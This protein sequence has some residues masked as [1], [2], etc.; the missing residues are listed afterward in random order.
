MTGPEHNEV[1]VRPYGPADQQVW[2]GVVEASRSRHFFFR[3]GYMDYHCDRFQ[4]AS[5][6][7]FEGETPVAVFPANRA[8]TEIVSHGGLTFGGLLSDAKLTTR[9]TVAALRALFA[10]YAGEGVTSLRYKAMPAIYHLVPAEEDLY[11]LF[12]A[13]ATLVRRDCAAALRPQDHPRPSKGRRAAIRRARSA[14]FEVDRD[15]AFAD[16]MQLE[17]QALRRRHGTAPVHTPAEME[18]LAGAFPDHIKLFTA[19]RDGE[20]YGGVLVYET[21]TVAHAQYIAGTEA[22]YDE[23]ALDAVLGHLIED[24]YADKRWFDFGISTT[25]DG[26]NL[27]TGLMRNKESFGGRAVAYDTYVVG[28]EDVDALG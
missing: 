19:R 22:A 24:V 17:D 7:L 1:E 2:D 14:G 4:D 6:I 12:V 9:R 8:G 11:A 21:P 20:L 25:E 18:L 3:R 26:R 16:F 27:N 5:R 10:A 13:D 23:N 15:E 28:L